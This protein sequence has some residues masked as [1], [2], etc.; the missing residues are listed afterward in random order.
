MWY[1]EEPI[2]YC[3]RC[4]D[5][6]PLDH[7]WRG[8]GTIIGAGGKE[9]RTLVLYSLCPGCGHR[10]SVGLDGPIWYRALYA[11]L[12]KLR[13]PRTRRPKM[14]AVTMAEVRRKAS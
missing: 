1:P 12:W 9:V 14:E 5:E 6:I 4:E 10:L 13:Y 8:T 3:K 7:F 11:W 2:T